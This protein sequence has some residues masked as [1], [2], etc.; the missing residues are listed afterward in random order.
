M[1]AGGG[2]ACRGAARG[3]GLRM[4][5]LCILACRLAR[6]APQP[7]LQS[8]PL[9]TQSPACPPNVLLPPQIIEA[10]EARMQPADGIRLP[11]RVV[12]LPLAFNERWTHD[13]INR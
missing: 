12:H 10:A 2:L 8:R 4:R 1:G 6:G 13:A 11:Y 3:R 5:A 9:C 7:I